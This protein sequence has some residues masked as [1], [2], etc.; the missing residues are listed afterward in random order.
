[1]GAVK[2]S[3]VKLAPSILSADFA[4]L[5]SEIMLLDK[6]GAD[7][8]HIDIMDGVFVPNISIGM[9]VQKTI[10][11][12]TDKVFDVHLMLQN[13]LLYIESVALAGAD[14]ITVHVESDGDTKTCIK[15]IKSSG[16]RAG[17]AIS[18]DT[19]VKSICDMLLDADLAGDMDLLL[20]MGVYP[21]FGNQKL[22]ESTYAKIREADEFIR[23]NDLDVE[24]E[25][26]GGVNWL[27]VRNI[28]ASGA[29][30]IVAGSLVFQGNTE[31]NMYRLRQLI[32]EEQC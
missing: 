27:N 4:N 30:V 3:P 22:I 6:C 13:P 17:L 14:R 15:R 12:Y 5:G 21:G 10:R 16:C 23:L 32:E 28:I 20:I 18:P 26:D 8:I 9:P 2:I 19:P 24:I 1:M 31:E 29:D 7:Y 25:V 11:K